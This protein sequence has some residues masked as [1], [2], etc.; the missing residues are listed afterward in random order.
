M[1]ELLTAA[2]IVFI[3]AMSAWYLGSLLL[4]IAAFWCFVG[5]GLL[6]ALSGQGDVSPWAGPAMV[7]WGTAC[8]T[9]LGQC[10]YRLRWGCWLTTS[11]P[12]VLATPAAPAS[13]GASRGAKAGPTRKSW[14]PAPSSLAVERQRSAATSA[15]HCG[16]ASRRSTPVPRHL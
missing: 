11:R 16:L 8:W 3:V 15:R 7:G 14:E 1:T 4:R 6:L 9:T 13:A 12:A 10:L 5:A 2:G